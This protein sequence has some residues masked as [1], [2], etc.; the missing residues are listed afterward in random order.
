MEI[1]FVAIRNPQHG[2]QNFDGMHDA[3][4]AAEKRSGCRVW[5]IGDQKIP[6]QNFVPLPNYFTTGKL[7]IDSAPDEVRRHWATA[8]L[9]RWLILHDFLKAKGPELAW[10]ILAL[11]YDV[12]VF[13]NLNEPYKEFL[14]FDFCAPIFGIGSSAAYSVHNMACLEAAVETIFRLAKT[15][16][17]LND[18]AV[19]SDVLQSGKWKVGNLLPETATGV[20][21]PN[22]HMGEDRY[23]MEPS[24]AP[25]WGHRTKK[26]TWAAGHPFFTRLSDEHLVQV[27]WIHCWGSYKNRTR[28]LIQK[29]G[30]L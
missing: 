15:V 1:V 20:F 30:I 17:N 21:D 11:D 14:P 6:C 5:M 22:M 18:M 29:A 10:P 3:I 26:I 16:K 4:L 19:W 25:M 23:E 12:L 27:H 2:G 13:S 8:S 28:E 9:L 24:S 7:L